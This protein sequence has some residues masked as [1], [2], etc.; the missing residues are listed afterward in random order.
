ML[1]TRNAISTLYLGVVTVRWPPL[2][3]DVHTAQ[4]RPGCGIDPVRPVVTRR[5]IN[6]QIF[7]VL[8]RD[9]GIGA[10]DLLTAVEDV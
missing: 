2:M 6:H 10:A 5:Q 4:D 7:P 9:D 8:P 1:F 3:G